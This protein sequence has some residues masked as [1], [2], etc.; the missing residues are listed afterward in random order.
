NQIIKSIAENWADI[1]T[2]VTSYRSGLVKESSF[3]STLSSKIEAVNQ[4]FKPNMHILDVYFVKYAERLLHDYNLLAHGKVTQYQFGEE[5]AL[6]NEIVV[7][8]DQSF[9]ASDETIAASSEQIKPEETTQSAGFF[10]SSYDQ[11]LE[12]DIASI[13]MGEP[14]SQEFPVQEQYPPITTPDSVIA[15]IA[16]VPENTGSAVNQEI[17]E[18]ASVQS[19]VESGIGSFEDQFLEEQNFEDVSTVDESLVS[20]AQPTV[21]M[22]GVFQETPQQ[23]E[24]MAVVDENEGIEEKGAE[25]PAAD[26]AGSSTPD[27]IADDDE[28]E[29]CIE[30][31][32]I[33]KKVEPDVVPDIKADPVIPQAPSTDFAGP[34]KDATRSEPDSFEQEFEMA[35]SDKFEDDFAMETIMDMD[36]SHLLRNTQQFKEETDGIII[37]SSKITPLKPPFKPQQRFTYIGKDPTQ[38]KDDNQQDQLGGALHETILLKSGD[39]SGEPVIDTMQPLQANV[40]SNEIEPVDFE[41]FLKADK[42]G[43][44]FEE[45]KDLEITGDDIANK[46]DSF[47]KI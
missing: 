42:N 37:P 25:L 30:I 22:P 6:K 9:N 11:N 26:I 40:Q 39:N 13:E 29:F 45:N 47:F 43:K 18:N 28:E 23:P 35:K 14:Q 5:P 3:K 34:T 2:L 46:I 32:D 17:V 24:A 31:A 15:E 20:N 44:N 7:S 16:D 38:K 41:D 36:M 12:K 21:E 4:I 19:D 1:D 8:E 10:D 27:A 33:D